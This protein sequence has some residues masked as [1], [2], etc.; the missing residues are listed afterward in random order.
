MNYD[1]CQLNAFIR[2]VCAEKNISVEE[3]AD[4]LYLS[5]E[6]VRNRYLTTYEKAR[7]NAR[8]STIM[9]IANALEVDPVIV[10]RYAMQ[11]FKNWR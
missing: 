8:V 9:N 6:S 11:D 5:K 4:R 7:P 10:F 2:K 1:G 3:L